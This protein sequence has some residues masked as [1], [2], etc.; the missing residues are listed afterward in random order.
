MNDK[1]K[2]EI[3]EEYFGI[4]SPTHLKNHNISMSEYK[5]LYPDSLIV[6]ENVSKKLADNARNNKNIGYKKGCK[7]EKHIT[8]NKGLTKETDNRIKLFSEKLKNRIFSDEHKQ[9][10]SLSKT[11]NRKEIYQICQKCGEI[12]GKSERKLCKKCSQKIRV[13]N[14]IN[15]M[16]GKKLT[17]EHKMKLLLARQNNKTINKPEKKVLESYGK[18]GL[19]YT[20]DRSKWVKF[21]DG[22]IK[23]PDF[24]F[25]NYNICIEVYGNY[26]HKND[27]PELLINKYKEIGWRCLV[28]WEKEINENSLWSLSEIINQFINYDNYFPYCNMDDLDYDMRY[29]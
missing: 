28:L 8:W 18:L 11:K 7:H 1:I 25:E 24:V 20:G 3:C 29:F 12:K 5:L 6:S 14:F 26:W 2:C 17:E 16:K 4:I 23:N 13:I 10:I 22:K 15:P 21:K 9:K 19:K 27:N